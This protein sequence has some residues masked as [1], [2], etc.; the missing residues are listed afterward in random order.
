M[1]PA[2]GVRSTTENHHD[3]LPGL[4]THRRRDHGPV[5]VRRRGMRLRQHADGSR[6]AALGTEPAQG[7]P[8]GRPGCLVRLQRLRGRSRHDLAGLRHRIPRPHC[9]RPRRLHRRDGPPGALGLRSPGRR[10]QGARPH[11]VRLPGA[12]PHRRRRDPGCGRPLLPELPGGSRHVGRRLRWN[13]HYHARQGCGPARALGRRDR[14]G[15]P[16]LPHRPT[17][18]GPVADQPGGRTQ[19][20]AVLRRCR[21][22]R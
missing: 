4:R 21:N 13:E 12:E 22:C 15:S 20:W 10:P 7:L 14:P 16:G 17:A 9:R 6:R 2:P 18:T 19:R 11:R 1:G 5:P 3:H 8:F